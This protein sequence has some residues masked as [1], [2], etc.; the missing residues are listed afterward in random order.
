MDLA[1]DMTLGG[2]VGSNPDL[3]S[4]S[5]EPVLKH[6]TPQLLTEVTTNGSTEGD[7]ESKAVSRCCLGLFYFGGREN[8]CYEHG[9][10]RQG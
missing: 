3:E 10:H 2:G 7:I 9:G 4:V 8:D 1:L 5:S 6:L